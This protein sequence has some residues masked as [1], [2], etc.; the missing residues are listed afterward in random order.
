MPENQSLT[1]LVHAR[2][3]AG[4][5]LFGASVDKPLVLF[6]VEM[7][8]QFLPL[9]KTT[10]DN[11]KNPPPKPDGTWDT[12]VVRVRSWDDAR[13]VLDKLQSGRHW[14]KGA[15]VDSIQALQNRLITGMVGT[16]AV[17]IQEWG[18]ILRELQGFCEQLRDLTTHPQNPM[19]GICVI[20]PT[21]FRGPKDAET[22]QPHLRGQ[23]ANTIPYL[24]DINGFLY[25]EHVLD[26]T[27]KPFKQ[28]ETRFL[29]TRR[30][31]L[32]EAGERVG[33]TIPEVFKLD[34]LTGKREDVARKNR[35]F[36]QLKRAV[37][38]ESG[39]RIDAPAATTIPDA[40][41]T[42]ENPSTTK[43]SSNA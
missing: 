11:P 33:G 39:Q 25:T 22:W 43:E 3:K 30:T 19:T 32:I 10:W 27:T 28:V 40:P 42:E 24:F 5:S 4:K 35:T 26:K 31:T 41:A 34:Q 7:G 37:Y 12:A 16:R 29:R 17:E 6:D 36:Q 21:I 15:T 18:E 38:A 1:T 9:R 8:S 13:Y 2:A 20:C 23:M 14:F